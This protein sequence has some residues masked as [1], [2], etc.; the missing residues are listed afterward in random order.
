[1]IVVKL[2][3][4]LGNQMFQYAAG[5]SL[6]IHHNTNLLLNKIS[7][8]EE[9]KGVFTKRNYELGC[10]GLEQS[11]ATQEDLDYFSGN[12]SGKFK[13]TLDRIFPGIKRKVTLYESGHIFHSNFFSMPADTCLVGFWQSEKYFKKYEDQIRKD[14]T[15]LSPVPS[16]LHEL[17]SRVKSTNSISLHV[18]RGDYVSLKTA[19]DF[20]GTPGLSYYEKAIEYIRKEQDAGEIFVFSD[21]LDWCRHNLSFDLPVTFVQQNN[22]PEWDMFLM[23]QSK[24][25]IIANSSYSWWGAWLNQNPGKIVILPEYWYRNVKSNSIDITPEG[26]I[27]V[28]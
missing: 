4:G 1:M 8:E 7:L 3:G 5:R 26:W 20:H 9:P 10:F 15:L 24:H 16:S 2:I 18:R 12:S 27:T 28:E 6:A 11:F 21:D 23:S 14:F 19:A 22:G 17:H 13:R 25:N